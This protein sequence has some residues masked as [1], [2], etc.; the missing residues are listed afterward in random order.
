M[1]HTHAAK[2]HVKA[3]LDT[4]P[5]PCVLVLNGTLGH[6]SALDLYLTSHLSLDVESN[7]ARDYPVKFWFR[8]DSTSLIKGVVCLKKRM[9]PVLA[10]EYAYMLILLSWPIDTL[11]V[12]ETGVFFPNKTSLKMAQRACRDGMSLMT[13]EPF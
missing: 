6:N 11:I 5:Y 10:L 3:S 1:I 2:P 4:F 7:E 8:P 13:L 9:P 12:F